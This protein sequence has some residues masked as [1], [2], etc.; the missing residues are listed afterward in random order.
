MSRRVQCVILFLGMLNLPNFETIS[1]PSYYWPHA[2]S[3]EY[4]I[5]LCFF[6][7]ESSDESGTVLKS[8]PIITSPFLKLYTSPSILLINFVLL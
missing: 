6:A 2:Y 4:F 8:P 5:F 3:I 1:M 7:V